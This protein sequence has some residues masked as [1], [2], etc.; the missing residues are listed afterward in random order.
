MSDKPDPMFKVGVDDG[1]DTSGILDSNRES[2]NRSQVA[3][4]CYF[5]LF[6]FVVYSVFSLHYSQLRWGDFSLFHTSDYAY[7]NYLADA[8]NH[9]QLHLRL[10]PE[11]IHDLV[12][13]DGRLYLYWPP[14]PAVPLMPLVAMFGVGFS[15]IFFTLVI[16]GLNVALTGVFFSRLQELQIINLSAFQHRS[17][18]ACFAFGTVHLTMGPLGR[19]WFTSQ[20]LGF[21][22]VLA[23]HLAAV[24]LRGRQAFV[25]AGCAVAAAIMTRN[26]L[27][28]ACLWPAYYLLKSH[29]NL[30]PGWRVRSAAAGL[31]PVVTA[32][33][34][35]AAYNWARFGETNEL[36]LT[37]HRMAGAF[38]TEFQVYGAFSA[39]YLPINLKYQYL[40][41]PFPLSA[42]SLMGGSLFLLTPLFFAAFFAFRSGWGLSKLALVLSILLTS[43]PILLLMGTGWVQFGPRY[44]LDFTLPLLMLT[45]MG[46]EKWP[47]SV[48]AILVM[49]S[50]VQYALGTLFLSSVLA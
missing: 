24:T 48:I 50:V 1:H 9:L 28:L 34:V 37:F 26:H 44:T 30:S 16:G 18:L 41:Y 40:V 5:G 2:L 3:F 10:I 33:M 31:A 23:A 11:R 12:V 19:V 35:L 27:F 7:F 22:F 25:L 45:A 32:L 39:H 4:S 8:F 14:F 36:G 49:I 13:V 38:S 47:R 15:D 46:I 29:G 17:L 6:A 20:L 43:I 21:L 42:E